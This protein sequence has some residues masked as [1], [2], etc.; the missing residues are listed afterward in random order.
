MM[1]ATRAAFWY[2]SL[3]LLLWALIPSFLFPN[4]PLDV[5]EGFAW[6]REM[7]LGYTKHPPMQAWL[8]ELSYHLT[9]GHT[10]GA[11]WLSSL[12]IAIAYVCIWQLSRRLGLAEW[13]AFW[14]IVMTSV[15]FYFTLPLPEFNPNILQIPVWAA[16]ILL[17]HRAL[18]KGQLLDWILLGAVAAFGLY[19]KYFVALLIGT[20]GLYALVFA[21]AR[22]CLSTPGPWVASLVGCLL[23]IPH[24][25]W[26]VDTGFVTLEYAASRSRG[27]QGLIDHLLNPLDFLLAQ[28]AT[29]AGLFIIAGLLLGF[30]GLKALAI[31]RPKTAAD[32]TIEANDRFLLW[33]AFLPLGVILLMS[34]ITGNEFKSMWGTPLF[35]LSGILAVRFLLPTNTFAPERRA[36]IG[37]VVIQAIF[38]GVI[39]GQAILEPLWKAKQSRIHYPGQES[40]ELLT[41]IWREEMKTPLRFVAGDMW[42]AAHVTLF[43]EDRPTMYLDHDAT[44]SPWVDQAELKENGVML[45]WSGDSD[46]P[47]SPMSGI[48]PQSRRQGSLVLP[49]ALASRM[50]PAIVNW[51]IITPHEVAVSTSH[52]P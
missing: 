20:I 24:L 50:P 7:A 30:S 13:K 49:F 42:T 46:K 41:T 12:S 28:I 38:L 47:P 52:Q 34:A 51:A 26:L 36:L 14:A 2:C 17:F 1:S 9:F 37:A 8:L 15:T 19:T 25:L 23:F 6:G 16:M 4:P 27:P 31:R 32:I 40:A 3:T 10:F 5:V 29:H 39:V 22:R 43:S 35:V 44:A 11:Y 45:V 21:D 48:Y 33:F 18:D